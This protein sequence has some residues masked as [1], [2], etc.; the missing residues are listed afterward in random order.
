MPESARAQ[1]P[2]SPV[3]PVAKK[4]DAP[5]PKTHG[6]KTAIAT[7]VVSK[8]VEGGKL[9]VMFAR[10]YPHGIR[11]DMHGYFAK[12]P[13]VKFTINAMHL[14]DQDHASA[15]I[16]MPPDLIN[17]YQDVVIGPR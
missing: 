14:M 16:D 2:K 13:N 3:G 5:L 8:K 10:G 1:A 6:S 9:L 12:A 4:E 7:R 17:A 11:E 15:F